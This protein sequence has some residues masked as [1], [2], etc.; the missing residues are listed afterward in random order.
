MKLIIVK[1][2]APC[3]RSLVEGLRTGD[4]Y[5]QTGVAVTVGLVAAALL[6]RRFR[7]AAA[8]RRPGPDA[9]DLLRRHDDFPA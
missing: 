1:I 5:V 8:E 4:P 6:V 7:R 3:L 9:D 2:L